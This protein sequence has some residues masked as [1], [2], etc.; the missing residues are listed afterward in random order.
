M[1]QSVVILALVGILTGC[2]TAGNPSIKSEER[3]SK[4]KIGET[5]KDEVR[6]LLGEPTVVHSS[7][8]SAAC[9]ELV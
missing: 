3:L 9:S 5:T 1:N 8:I 6:Q 4:I 2:A 7:N